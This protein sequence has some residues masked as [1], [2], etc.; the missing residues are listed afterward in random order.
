MRVPAPCPYA[1]LLAEQNSTLFEKAKREYALTAFPH[2][3]ANPP[4]EKVKGAKRKKGQKGD[5]G[6]EDPNRFD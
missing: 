6:T 3:F 5:I 2:P 1:E 4:A